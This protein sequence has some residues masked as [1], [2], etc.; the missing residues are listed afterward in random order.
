MFTQFISFCIHFLFHG[1]S[2]KTWHN[3]ALFFLAQVVGIGL[4]LALVTFYLYSP[5]FALVSL[6]IL[7]IFNNGASRFLD[8]AYREYLHASAFQVIEEAALDD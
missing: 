2:V 6:I 8:G 3:W 4:F 1:W 7:S 5:F